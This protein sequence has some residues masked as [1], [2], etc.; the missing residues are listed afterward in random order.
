[1]FMIGQTISHYKILEK[2]GEG[3]MGVVYKAQD[4]KLDRLVA[5]KFLPPHLSASEQDKARFVQEA[6]AAAA[7]NHPNVCSVMDIQEQ[8]HQMFIVMEFVEGQTLRDKGLNIPM[9]QAI[10]IGVQLS[11]GLAAAHEKGISHRD[12]KP[13]NI[14]VRKDGRVQIMD[15]GLA[16]LRQ[17][18]GASRLT[19]EGSTIGTIG[20]MSPEQVQ[21]Q[22]TDHRTDIYSLGILL[23]ELISGQSPYKGVHETAIIYEIVNEDPL[24][25]SSIKPD[26]DPDLDAMILD[27]MAK[28]P[29]DRF[30]S[31]AELARSLRRFKRESS[32]QRVSRVTTTR[33]V[34]KAGETPLS[35]VP[36]KADW[37]RFLWPAIS[38][39]MFAAALNLAWQLWNGPSKTYRPVMRFSID[40]PQDA[41]IGGNFST[42]IDISP[43]GEY[44][45]Y[46]SLVSGTPQLC[47]RR[48][49]QLDV[50]PIAGTEGAGYP[51]FSP[52]GQWIAFQVGDKLK[53]ISVFGGAPQ[54]ICSTDG[55]I[56]A[57]W[58]GSNNIIYYGHLNK[59]VM[60]VSAD[61][62]NPEAAATLDSANGEISHRFPQ[63]LPDGKTLMF[64]VKLNNIA[65][66]DEA[67]IAAQ[68]LDGSEK[69]ILIRGGTYSRYLPTGHILYV[70]G[71]SFF[72]VPFDMDRLEVT[73]PPTQLFDGGWLNP[74]SGDA[75]YSVSNSGV[76]AYV[77]LG[78]S[79][80]DIN[81]VTWMDRRGNMSTLLGNPRPYFSGTISPDG[82]KIALGIN[83][84]N[85]DIW[86]YHLTRGTTTRLT[87]GGGNHG[88]PIWTPDGKHVI[89]SAEKGKSPNLYRKTWDGSGNE[90]RLTQSDQAQQPVAVSPDGKHLSFVQNGDI[91]IL[92]LNGEGKPFPFIQSPADEPFAAFSSDGRWVAYTSNES[93]KYE[94]F[95]TSFP[96]R[97]GKWQ[98]SSRGGFLVGWSRSGREL[99]YVSGA[100]LMAVD[101]SLQPSFDFSTPRK[102]CD[103]P[104]S[105]SGPRDI[106]SDGQKFLLIASPTQ[107]ITA[108][109]VNVVLE[110]FEE[111]KEKF[112]GKEN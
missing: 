12:I 99:F 60:R 61:G 47:L 21:G 42:A 20:Y 23:Y 93:G 5:L 112:S 15:F 44:L 9:K 72:V 86:V 65:T 30:Q 13:E 1:M 66:F 16:K 8:D 97:E 3:G 34:F 32:R 59:G 92:P 76:F 48:M 2:L 27:C 96:K 4:T 25:L 101:V 50:S 36:E 103:V 68:R 17:A 62:G 51:F 106:S 70:R 108:T 105:T 111:L 100:S 104:S 7:L 80:F 83:A 57:G 19:K 6:K 88:F 67:I 53:K 63:L 87:F 43:N 69:K 75:T 29:A 84:A 89:Y 10:E 39:L 81:T 78:S 64:T 46:A 73:G 58:W 14:M 11:E 107:Q 52:D 98:V 28:D 85:D 41:P 94:V 38:L 109:R 82:Q 110:W 40:L 54:N 90:E 95:V 18:S 31:A 91:W 79:S 77:P 24:P 102:L 35:N 49:D 74:F 33:Q 37:K 56:R 45:V 26:I 55:L 71:K 22:E